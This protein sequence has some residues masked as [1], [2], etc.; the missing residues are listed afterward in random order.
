MDREPPPPDSLAAQT[1]AYNMRIR[2]EKK[3]Q[4][5]Q[6]L[7]DVSSMLEARVKLLHAEALRRA[8]DSKTEFEGFMLDYRDLSARYALLGAKAFI[9]I[10]CKCKAARGFEIHTT[11][12]T[13]EKDSTFGDST[14]QFKWQ[15]EPWVTR[16]YFMEDGRKK[17]CM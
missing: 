13:D 1:A 10:F 5:N 4:L 14:A 7:K 12:A 8:G 3:L 15:G 16:V 6:E 11:I 2:E 9:D 17:W